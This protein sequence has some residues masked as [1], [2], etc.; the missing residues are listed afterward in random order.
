MPQEGRIE[1]Q[2]AALVVRMLDRER[3]KV[4]STVADPP[5]LSAV[6]LAQIQQQSARLHAAFIDRTAGMEI[7]TAEDLKAC[8][9]SLC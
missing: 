9:R 5:A 7:L 1:V 2:V 4:V 6:D 3:I 8:I